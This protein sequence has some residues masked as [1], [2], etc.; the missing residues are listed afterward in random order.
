VVRDSLVNK[1]SAGAVTVVGVDIW[2][3]GDSLINAYIG[4]TGVTFPVVKNG[5]SIGTSYSVIANSIVVIDQTG[6]VQFV[7]QLGTSST[8]DAIIRQMVS[9]AA[10]VT[11]RLL[12]NRTVR[13]GPSFRPP[14]A[15]AGSPGR[16]TIS[17]R[18]L[19]RPAPSSGAG[20]VVVR[21]SEPMPV[22][23]VR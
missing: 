8:T 18:S 3:S 23:R 4:A 13:P 11:R 22:I 5:A 19:V 6:L 17:G 20:I 12:T 15:P 9:D 14:R 7:Q 21:S 10:S 2:N 1:F 16:F